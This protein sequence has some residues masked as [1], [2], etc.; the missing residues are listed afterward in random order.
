MSA[1]PLRL[2]VYGSF[3]KG[4]RD[5]ALLAGATLEGEAQT[6]A[7][8]SLFDL[9]VYPALVRGGEQP[10]VGETYLVLPSVRFHLDVRKECPL[11]FQR[12][13]IRLSDGSSADAYV[14]R[15]DQVRGRRKIWNGDWRRR[16]EPRPRAS[17]DSPFARWAKGRFR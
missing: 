6:A 11:L 12:E 2:F 7:E 10:I 1:E 16:F 3:L 8:F 9:G 14:M 5:H 4:E 17:A 13:A 15:W